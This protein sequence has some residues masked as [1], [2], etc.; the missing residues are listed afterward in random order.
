M[1]TPEPLKA[2]PFYRVFESPSG[3]LAG[4]IAISV[5]HVRGLCKI[6]R[7]TKAAILPGL[8]AAVS[9][10]FILL[11][12]AASFGDRTFVIGSAEVQGAQRFET[13]GDFNRKVRC[14]LPGDKVLLQE[15]RTFVGVLRLR[16]CSDP[17][18]SD[19][20]IEVRSFNPRAP[21]D[22]MVVHSNARIDS[23]V[24]VGSLGLDWVQV[25][26]EQLPKT[27]PRPIGS[28]AIYR[29]GPLKGDEN[30]A[31]VFMGMTRLLLA[32]APSEPLR[33]DRGRFFR[34]SQITG[35]ERGCPS[36]ACLR[37]SD[38]AAIELIKQTA[39]TPAGI[40]EV[41]AVVRS[42][43]WSLAASLVV[44]LDRSTG[45]IRLAKAIAGVG[46]PASSLPIPGFGFLLVNSL[47]FLDSHGEWYFDRGS[48]ILY[49]AWDAAMAGSP[50][51]DSAS[52]VFASAKGGEYFTHAD[53]GLSFWGNAAEK[54]DRY[55]LSISNL[56]IVRSA[57]HA[58]R[59]YRA[60]NVSV[61]DVRV[62]Q[63]GQSGIAVGEI[64]GRAEVLRSTILNSASNGIFV[65]LSSEVV[66]HD[67]KI[68]DSGQLANQEQF[69]M[70]MNG[71]RAGSFARISIA[72]NEIVGSGY[73]GVMLSEPA[74]GDALAYSVGI[75]VSG[76][77]ISAFCKMLNDCGAIYINGRQKTGDVP[78][79]AERSV[80]R[81]IG[82]EI[83]SPI[84][85]MDGAPGRAEG[86]E[87]S[88]AK[89]GAF[90]RMLGAVYLDHRAGGYDIADN[91]ITGDY[92][93]YGWR[94][95]NKGVQNS[96]SRALIKE[97]S[98]KGEGYSCYT[99]HLEACNSFSTSR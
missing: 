22:A 51:A 89:N 9:G 72:R 29:L 71:V 39:S 95:F 77:K 96:C 84:G 76:N 88:N 24:P 69:G 20:S 54:A 98:T 32:R 23:A 62:N 80:K 57:G 65:S 36:V 61:T 63:S 70:D 43:P 30:V 55:K 46:M 82:N 78:S 59:T 2:S 45:E 49:L 85:N 81:I 40:G 94:I 4:T 33:G 67:N 34:S 16:A 58:I 35:G 47:S 17:G 7:R 42:S 48:R 99:P 1:R 41:Y 66:L 90:V 5:A 86:G 68:F 83:K 91:R 74:A 11:A 60:P 73:A 15:G 87:F 52:L 13:L 75:D 64:G 31:E 18:T 26:F 92:Q 93:P 12:Q 3:F 28:L 6:Q 56:T 8:A 53:A 19:R 21:H 10:F 44:D 79:A 25:G 14:V 50:S 38:P 97:C 27:I 37:T